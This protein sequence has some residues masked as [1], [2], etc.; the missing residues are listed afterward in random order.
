[1]AA[2]GYINTASMM[3]GSRFHFYHGPFGGP[4]TY[5]ASRRL[6]MTP[7]TAAASSN[8]RA[9]GQYRDPSAKS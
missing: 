2:L 6:S 9:R 8:D 7:S 4:G 3:K 5:G 1:M